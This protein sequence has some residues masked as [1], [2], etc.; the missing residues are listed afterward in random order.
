[1]PAGPPFCL[2]LHLLPFRLLFLRLPLPPGIHA[3]ACRLEPAGDLAERVGHAFG[4]QARV[5]AVQC[6]AHRM[7]AGQG[8]RPRPPALARLDCSAHD[9]AA[10]WIVPAPL[11]LHRK[12]DAH[13]RE[14]LAQRKRRVACRRAPRHVRPAGQ[15][16]LERAAAQRGCDRKGRQDQ[17]RAAGGAH[18]APDFA[19]ASPPSL[20]LPFRPS[21]LEP[22]L[23]RAHPNA[24]R[25]GPAHGG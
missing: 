5:R 22:H 1:M 13:P 6:S 7:A 9:A 14:R 11:D 4:R 17:R 19:A 20:P 15:Y 8:R 18:V 10:L 3:A 2:A 23:G 16:G 21:R 12:L 25:P 24:A